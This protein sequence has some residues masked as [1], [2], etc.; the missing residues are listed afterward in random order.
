MIPLLANL[1]FKIEHK[2]NTYDIRVSDS[3]NVNSISQS[4]NNQ[5]KQ[6]KKIE[7]N[8]TDHYFLKKK[9]MQENYSIDP[10]TLN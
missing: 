8:T 6:A 3:T 10:A 7:G 1:K 2:R 9:K 4:I 5:F